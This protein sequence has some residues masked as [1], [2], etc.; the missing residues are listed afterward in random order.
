MGLLWA[1]F[2]LL[3]L[4]SQGQIKPLLVGCTVTMLVTLYGNSCNCG[5][6]SLQPTL[7]DEFPYQSIAVIEE[8]RVVFP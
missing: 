6:F 8:M 2:S 1:S 4:V 5:V 7:I 3:V